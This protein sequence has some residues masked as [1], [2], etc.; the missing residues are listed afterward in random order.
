MTPR[1]LYRLGPP[2]HK[3]INIY[4]IIDALSVV[5]GACAFAAGLGI[6]LEYFSK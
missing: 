6:I 3:G 1:I 5:L 4:W 2:K